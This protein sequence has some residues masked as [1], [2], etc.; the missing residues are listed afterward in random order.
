MGIQTDVASLR[1]IGAIRRADRS[2]AISLERLSTGKRVNRAADDPAGIIAITNFKS[3]EIE[4]TKSIEALEQQQ[5]Y[6]SAREGSLM[7]V[8]DMLIELNSLVIQAAN[9]AGMSSEERGAL[10]IQ[11]D[12]ILQTID[13]LGQTTTFKGIQTLQHINTTRLGAGMY[14]D[15]SGASCAISLG[16]LRA[17]GRLNLVSGDTEAAQNAVKSALDSIT[18]ERASLGAQTGALDH[19]MDA[20]RVELENTVAARGQIED[21]DYASETAALMRER[22]KQEAAI[23]VTRMAQDLRAEAVLELL[24]SVPLK[25]SK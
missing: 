3:R 21:T 14:T 8:S 7:P 5:L 1:G 16:D 22:V 25:K 13:R 6:F 19:Q 9:T 20:L 11:A 18:T 12:S 17:G 10:Q 24:K 15:P 2:I 4:I 23:T